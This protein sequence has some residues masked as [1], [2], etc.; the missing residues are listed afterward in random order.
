[1]SALPRKLSQAAI[2]HAERNAWRGDGLMNVSAIV[3]KYHISPATFCERQ[4]NGWPRLGY[5]PIPEGPERIADHGYKEKTY[6]ETE[7]DKAFTGLQPE[8]KDF[9]YGRQAFVK[10]LGMIGEKMVILLE[11]DNLID[12]KKVSGDDKNDTAA[13]A[14]SLAA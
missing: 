3:V 9:I 14:E 10:G 7:V 6:S 1:M 8:S 4:K 11:I 13:K 12:W 2:D 5:N